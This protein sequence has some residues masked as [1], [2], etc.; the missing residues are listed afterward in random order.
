MPLLNLAMQNDVPFNVI[1]SATA[2]R[3]FFQ[4]LGQAIGAAVFGVVL[5]TTLTSQITANLNPIIASLPAD[6]QSQFDP[7]KM[8]QS[9]GS[10]GSD[11][12][13]VDIGEKIAAQVKTQFDAQRSLLTAALRDADPKAQALSL[14]HI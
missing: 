14:I 7:S 8:R 2:N 6:V 5:S 10:E 12:K 1:G 4:Q 9:I 11:G 13:P 3:Q